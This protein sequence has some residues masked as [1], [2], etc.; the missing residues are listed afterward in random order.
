MAELRKWNAAPDDL[1][2]ILD[3]VGLPDAE[4]WPGA[5]TRRRLLAELAAIRDQGYSRNLATNPTDAIAT[6]FPAGEGGVASI[7]SHGP[8]GSFG[9]REIERLLASTRR[10]RAAL[11]V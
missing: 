6:A 1:D 7:G 3:R 10:V 9:R 2:H 11:A 4:R 5:D 8:A